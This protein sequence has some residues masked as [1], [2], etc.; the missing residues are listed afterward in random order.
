MF[1][2]ARYS[3]AALIDSE[4][5]IRKTEERLHIAKLRWEGRD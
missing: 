1:A 3:I 5:R 2:R 4:G